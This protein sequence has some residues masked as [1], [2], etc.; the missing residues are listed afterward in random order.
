MLAMVSLVHNGR[1]IG[2]Q[3]LQ[4]PNLNVQ[5]ARLQGYLLAIFL[6]AGAWWVGASIAVPLLHCRRQPAL[7]R[8][9][10]YGC[11]R[12]SSRNKANTPYKV[13]G[14]CT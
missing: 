9:L 6:A 2:G 7:Q 14:R 10:L 1:Y 5:R 8:S 3:D 13:F 4:S 11:C 12:D